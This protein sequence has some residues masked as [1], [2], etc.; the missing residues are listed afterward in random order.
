MQGVYLVA[1]LGNP[2]V[3]YDG[4]RHNAGFLAVDCLCR[5]IGCKLKAERR[6]EARCG[7]GPLAGKETLFCQPQTFM[8]ISGK[9]V[10]NLVS[11]YKI[12]LDRVLIVA[13]DAD[14]ELGRIRLRL[15]GSSGGHNGLKSVEQALRTECY[16][17]LKIGVGRREQCSVR[18][19]VLGR[20]EERE[21]EVLARVLERAAD[22]VAAA[23]GEGFETAMNRYNGLAASAAD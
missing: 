4:T 19:H 23:V 20:F 13:D 1:G 11:F 14:L 10:A 8:N 15:R 16:A 5:R 7:R 21:R 3:A 12:E 9:A 17:R 6:F 2:G 18:R 22:A